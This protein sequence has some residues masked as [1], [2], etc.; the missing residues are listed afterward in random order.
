MRYIKNFESVK[1]NPQIGD[2]VI[3]YFKSFENDPD[4]KDYYIKTHLGVIV[5][6]DPKSGKGFLP[7]EIQYEDN[8][9]HIRDNVRPR[10]ILCVNREDIQHWSKNKEDLEHIIKANKYNL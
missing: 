10:D 9:W 1:D 4:E 6:I 8:I 3:I 5:D 2:Y 7:Y